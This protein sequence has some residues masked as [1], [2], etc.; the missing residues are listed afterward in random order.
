MQ[1]VRGRISAFLG[2]TGLFHFSFSVPLRYFLYRSNSSFSV[3]HTKGEKWF[4]YRSSLC[5]WGYLYWVVVFV[6]VG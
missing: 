5:V 1:K 6:R 2:F 4:V 3:A